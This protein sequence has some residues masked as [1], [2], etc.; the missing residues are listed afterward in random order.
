MSAQYIYLVHPVR[1]LHTREPTYKIGKTTTNIQKYILTNYK[2]CE[3]ILTQKVLDCHTLEQN[4]IKLFD[5]NFIKRKDLGNEYYTGDVEK[6]ISFISSLIHTMN[7]SYASKKQLPLLEKKIALV[8][9]RINKML[10]EPMLNDDND[11]DDNDGNNDNNINNS[12]GDVNDSDGDVND[13]DSVIFN[14]KLP[15][16]IT[17]NKYSKKKQE[18]TIKS[19]CKHIYD[20]KPSWYLEGQYVDIDLIEDAYKTYFDKD[21]AKSIISR[22]LKDILFTQTSRPGGVT[23]KKLVLYTELKKTF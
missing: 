18:K 10:N 21:I 6:M 8:S 4:I 7:L 12:D 2:D 11:N 19:F 9:G 17:I 15:N 3:S 16:K 23:M 5:I 13:S 14:I 1:F 20:T 22:N